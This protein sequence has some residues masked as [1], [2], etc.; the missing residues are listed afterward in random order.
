MNLYR[1]IKLLIENDMFNVLNYYLISFK[2]VFV[3]VQMYI[4]SVDVHFVTGYMLRAIFLLGCRFRCGIV[5][6]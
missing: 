2:Y 1:I 6:T 5:S 4:G 3:D